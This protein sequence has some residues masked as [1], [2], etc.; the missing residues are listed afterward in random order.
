[1]AKYITEGWVESVIG[2]KRMSMVEELDVY[3]A[4]GDYGQCI[5][6]MM[7]DGYEDTVGRTISL[8]YTSDPFGKTLQDLK[9]ELRG[10]LDLFNMA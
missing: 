3:D 10:K 1:M 4:A 8:S 9:T 2:K 6:I 7:L 5:D